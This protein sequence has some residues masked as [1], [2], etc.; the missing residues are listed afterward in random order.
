MKI[1]TPIIHV[2]L[3][4]ETIN[5][6]HH[7]DYLNRFFTLRYC[8]DVNQKYNDFCVLV[9]SNKVCVVTLAPSHPLLC[10]DIE[11][12]NINFQ[13][14]KN[15][16]RLDNKISGKHKRNAQNVNQTA[17]L[18]FV[19][20]ADDKVYTIYSTIP[21]KLLEMNHQLENNPQKIRECSPKLY[22]KQCYIAIILPGIHHT[23]ESLN[24]NFLTPE[25]YEK[26]MLE[27][28]A[29]KKVEY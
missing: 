4:E 25:E 7:K 5:F 16:N 19:E 17:P 13:V 1:L 26:A 29:P 28:I 6:E 27:R 8:I 14:S 23:I 12:R 21:G 20:C 9:H 10:E 22:H 3:I 24:K 11:I 18:C 2:P 15:I